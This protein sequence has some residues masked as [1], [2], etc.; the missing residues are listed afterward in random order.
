MKLKHPPPP[1][2]T[3]EQLRNHYLV[4]KSIAERLK[5]ANREERKRIYREMYDELFRKV[6]DHPRLTRRSSA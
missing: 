1:G 6:P 5:R 3:E 4:E 2:R